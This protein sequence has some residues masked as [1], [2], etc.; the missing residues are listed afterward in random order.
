MLPNLSGL[1]IK[2]RPCV[3]RPE[4]ADVGVTLQR[5]SALLPWMTLAPGQAEPEVYE[6]DQTCQICSGLLRWPASGFERNDGEI[7]IEQ[8]IFGALRNPDEVEAARAAFYVQADA[9][10]ERI[11][12]TNPFRTQ[13][14]LLVPG[15]AHQFH[16]A[17]IARWHRADPAASKCPV[18]STPI[19][20]TIRT[21]LSSDGQSRPGVTRQRSASLTRL[22][23]WSD[24]EDADE[25]FDG[26]PVGDGDLDGDDDAAP[27]NPF[28]DLGPVVPVPPFEDGDLAGQSQQ[29]DVELPP[30]EAETFA[31]YMSDV[32]NELH[33]LRTTIERF[34]PS[35]RRSAAIPQSYD[36]MVNEVEALYRAL[37]AQITIYEQNPTGFAEEGTPLH[38][39]WEVLIGDVYFTYRSFERVR[40]Q[41][42][43]TQNGS[44]T[45]GM[46]VA[47]RRRL[48]YLIRTMMATDSPPW[49]N[50]LLL[51]GWTLVSDEY[52]IMNGINRTGS[53]ELRAFG[54][55]RSVTISDQVA[56]LAAIQQ[57]RA[58]V[59]T[60]TPVSQFVDFLTLASFLL[61]AAKKASPPTENLEPLRNF[62]MS[63]TDDYDR[64]LFPE[65]SEMTPLADR[66]MRDSFSALAQDV[67]VFFLPA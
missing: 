7:F 66:E 36:V 27:D 65:P 11:R 25:D 45:F 63:L 12:M 57:I 17:C 6:E 28:D 33:N 42:H 24:D 3:K 30:S 52:G 35:Y 10:A 20:D 59:A 55:Q 22:M 49:V 23:L 32:R 64:R 58:W 48:I 44:L 2:C 29:P 54:M 38:V 18:C 34:T 19:A 46:V 67:F 62:Q 31:E 26:D 43:L 5:F 1:S 8:N 15:C 37:I 13:I 41:L 40:L 16:R 39:E 60:A 56:T 53:P 21:S 61:E 47:F 51:T 9:A 14:E 50:P 4:A